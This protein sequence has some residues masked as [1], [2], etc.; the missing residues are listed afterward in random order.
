MLDI[1]DNP[2]I[3]SEVYT[4]R[5]AGRTLLF[6]PQVGRGL[7]LVRERVNKILKL[8]TGA[9]SISA[10]SVKTGY[11]PKE[12]ISVLGKLEQQGVVKFGG[13][14]PDLKPSSKP[15]KLRAWIHTT[16]ACN[17][18]CSY[19][20][21]QKNG[22][23]MDIPTARKSVEA[24]FR[25]FALHPDF[26]DWLLICLSGGEPLTNI[27]VVKEILQYSKQLS[28]QT[29]VRRGIVLLTNGTIITPPIIDMIKKYDIG[30]SISIDGLREFNK[31]RMF[32]GGKPAADIILKN[33]DL[34][35]ENGIYPFILTTITLEN[36]AGLRELT[37]YLM[38]KELSFRYSLLRDLATG[39][40]ISGHKDEVIET[41]NQCYD[42]I[43]R[44]LPLRTRP[45]IHNF[46]SLA[47]TNGCTRGC[48]I[49]VRY[50]AISHDGKVYLCHMDINRRPAVG[51]VDDID[52]LEKIRKQ[53]VFP[54]LTESASVMAY[55][56]CKECAW[57]FQCGGSCPMLTK[58]AKG[59]VNTSSP[60]CDIVQAVI[61]RLLRVK[62]LNLIRREQL[63]L[64][65]SKQS[66]PIASI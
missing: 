48:T 64:Y 45:F 19:C 52:I 34:L 54:E 44:L 50:L 58:L 29:G 23:S 31:N 42:I 39:Y 40:N 62:A 43:E 56:N 8:C 38:S 11:Q 57:K 24:L 41:L 27:N 9:N 4:D 61:P 47:L 30:V 12:I 18:N 1:L 28:A 49:G 36:L 14:K 63:T 46:E 33:I 59:R 21:I 51:S 25:V 3:P 65:K 7:V 53:D 26:A 20:Y 55:D 16:N 15:P 6:N 5:V 17:L 66:L 32:S 60:Y 37:K 10:I 35:I 2:T 22:A 13:H